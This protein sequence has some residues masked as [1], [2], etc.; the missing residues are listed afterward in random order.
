MIN[1]IKKAWTSIKK[2]QSGQEGKGQEPP[3]PQT[4]DQDQKDLEDW[5][6]W[7]G[8]VEMKPAASS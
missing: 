3:K 7:E 8:M 2:S 1:R 5:A 6:G 4:W